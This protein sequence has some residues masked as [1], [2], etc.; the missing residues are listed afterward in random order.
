MTDATQLFK[1]LYAAFI[2]LNHQGHQ[3]CNKE[4]NSSH[5]PNLVQ[6]SVNIYTKF[7]EYTV[8]VDYIISTSTTYH[9]AILKIN[10]HCVLESM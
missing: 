2:I 3:S 9:H 6:I 8:V 1:D 5:Q 7:G 10:T 4:I